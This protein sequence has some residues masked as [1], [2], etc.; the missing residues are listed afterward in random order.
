MTVLVILGVLGLFVVVAG[1]LLGELLD[2][3]VDAVVPGDLGPGVTPAL[4]AAVAAFGFGGAL[5]LQSGDVTTGVA[6]AAGGLG[7]VVVGG[8][9]FFLARSLIGDAVPPPRSESLYGLFGV[10]VTPIPAQG[11]GEISV[12]VHGSHQKLSARADQPLPTRTSV[13]VLE[14]LS[15]TSVLVAPADPTFGFQEIPS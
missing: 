7:A 4:G 9:S 1:I 8:A 6:L 3:A 11:Y 15:S 2:G 14:V 5:A 10:V 13:Y 12:V